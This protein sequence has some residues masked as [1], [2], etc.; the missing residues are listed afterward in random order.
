MEGLLLLSNIILNLNEL[1][2]FSAFDDVVDVIDNS[3]ERLINNILN[4]HNIHNIKSDL[5]RRNLNR[6]ISNHMKVIKYY[7]NYNLVLKEL[8]SVL[9]ERELKV[10]LTPT[11]KIISNTIDGINC[12]I[13]YIGLFYNFQKNEWDKLEL[14]KEIVHTSIKMKIPVVILG[15]SNPLEFLPKL[16]NALSVY[17]N[18]SNYITPYHYKKRLF[19]TPKRLEKNRIQKCPCKVSLNQMVSDII[20]QYQLGDDIYKI[21]KITDINFG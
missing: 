2:L 20:D 19:D 18:N 7:N 8:D 3:L 6:F 4:I 21:L 17:F 5:R 11:Q 1:K 12:M 14:L 9:K 15:E 16:N 13:I 10:K